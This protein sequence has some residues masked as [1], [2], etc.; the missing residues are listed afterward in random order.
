MQIETE[1]CAVNAP[2]SWNQVS[3]QRLIRLIYKWEY[4]KFMTMFYIQARLPILFIVKRSLKASRM[5]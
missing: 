2:L 3:L 5:Q 4:N 1:N